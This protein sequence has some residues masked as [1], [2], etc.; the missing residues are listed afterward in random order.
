MGYSGKKPLI[1]QRRPRKGRRLQLFPDL[2]L[3]GLLFAGLALLIGYINRSE[4]AL[5]GS[6]YVIDG[7]TLSI[8]KRRIRMQGIDAP[9][10]R[11]T[12]ET[13]GQAYACGNLS[14]NAL[15]QKIEHQPVRCMTSGHDQYGRDLARC[16]RGDIDL[17]G[18]MVEQGFAVSY[19]DYRTEEARAR[20]A[21]RGIWSGTFD[22][23]QDWRKAN[24]SDRQEETEPSASASVMF[25]IWERMTAAFTWIFGHSGRS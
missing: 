21:R 1:Q 15:L 19:Y 12:C 24:R 20:A 23:P 6:A 5:N 11:Q 22:N 14:R 7:D 25:Y 13:N 3:T 2:V 17:N 8:D 16:F 18:W 10:L 9:E 4:T